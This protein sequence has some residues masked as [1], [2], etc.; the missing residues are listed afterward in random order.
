[1]FAETPELQILFSTPAVS[2]E[3]KKAVLAKVGAQMALNPL[4]INFLSVVIDHERM[5][6]LDEILEAL[7]SVLNDRLGIAVAEITTARPLDD[8]EKSTLAGALGNKTGKKVEMKFALDPRLIGGV[9]ARVGS[10][11][12]DG[13]VRG[14]LNRL[15]AELTS[16]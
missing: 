15:R 13:S 1:L 9:V 3:K 5:S 8:T 12:Y 10:T 7:Q 14:Y 4:T 16:D 11:I 2:A 6:M